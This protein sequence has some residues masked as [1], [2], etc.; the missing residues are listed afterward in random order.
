MPDRNS[1]AKSMIDNYP[2]FHEKWMLLQ[3]QDTVRHA[4]LT[5]GL[6]RSLQPDSVLEIGPYHGAIT[7]LVALA[8]NHNGKGEL[9]T[10]DNFTHVGSLSG[11]DAL[12]ANIVL[13]NIDRACSYRYG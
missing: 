11:A 1:P 4:W 13:R 8:L 12:R 10:I 5:Y 3:P 7:S 2:E 9:T 6:V